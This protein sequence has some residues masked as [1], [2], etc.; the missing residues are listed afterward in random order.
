MGASAVG[1]DYFAVVWPIGVA[2]VG[3][4]YGE[5][6]GVR[7]LRL[8]FFASILALSITTNAGASLA[9]PAANIAPSPNFDSSGTCSS[10]GGGFTCTNPCIANPRSWPVRVTTPSCTM[11]VLSALNRARTR[12]GISPMVLPSNWYRLSTPEQ[13]FVIVDLERVARGYPPYLGLNANLSRTAL[14]AARK[15]RDPLPGPGFSIGLDS[16]GVEGFGS[17]WA[18]GL[19]PLVADYLWMYDDGWGGDRAATS[20]YDCTSASSPGCWAHRDELLGA[21][22][23][24]NP[25][26]GRGCSTCEVGAGASVVHGNSSYS[27]LIELPSAEPPAMTFTWARNVLPYLAPMTPPTTSTTTQPTTSQ[28]TTTTQ[29]TVQ[30]GTPAH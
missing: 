10:N 27:V 7:I 24:Y 13:L 12:E 3:Y 25:G 6:V 28:T 9:N 22:P 17:V 16:S 18:S 19:S 26:V 30:S 29:P 2:C 5:Y 11:Y 21:D 20:N 23:G 15:D 8:T 1:R 14:V 4:G